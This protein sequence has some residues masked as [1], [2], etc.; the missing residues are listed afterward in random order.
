MIGTFRQQDSVD[1]LLK[2]LKS[3]DERIRVASIKAL[4]SL[5][6]AAAEKPIIDMY[7]KEDLSTR[8]EILRTLEV[9]GS[10]HSIPFLE[11]I[12]RQ[13]IEDFPLVIQAVRALLALGN[14]GS[15]VVDKIAGQ[16]EPK[17]Q[18]VINHAKDKRL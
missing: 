2:L 4:R 18:L 6:A 9:V 15:V 16:A 1:I 13:P 17:L 8:T 7:P 5:S 3:D 10:S 11:K 14:T 12:I